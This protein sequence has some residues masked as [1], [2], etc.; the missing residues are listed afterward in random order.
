MPKTPNKKTVDSAIEKLNEVRREWMRRPGVTAVDVG[1]KI[2]D[3][4]M[5]DDVALRVHVARKKPVADLS[6]SEVFNTTGKSLTKQGGFPVDVIEG[7]YA[8][9]DVSTDRVALEDLMGEVGVGIERTTAFN[10]LV[11]G[12]SCG[13]PRVTAGTLGAIVFDRAS[14]RPMILSNWHVLAGGSAAAV[15]EDIL[16]PGRVDGGTEA[17]ATLTRMRL[18]SSM[19]AAVATLN[20]ARAHSRDIMNIGTVT[21]TD[22]ATLGMEVEKSGRTT[23][24]TKGIVDGVSMSVSIDYGDPGVVAFTNQIRIVPRPPWPAVD[25]EI[26][27]GGDSGSI[28]LNERTNRAVGL[29]FGG[30]RNPS[31]ASAENALANP[32]KPVASAL[33]F[34]FLPIFC[35]SRPIPTRPVFNICQRYPEICDLLIR[36]RI[37]IFNPPRPRPDPRPFD[38][39]RFLRQ[40][41]EMMEAEEHGGGGGGGCSCGGHSGEYDYGQ[42]Y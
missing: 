19:D 26:S 4:V 14:C 11:G 15:G 7:D 23:G 38:D 40:L 39:L 21:G 5:T 41:L 35:P 13:N 27:L 37:P 8:P 32:I 6:S 36:R 29:H 22:D 10:P 12:I 34:S 31:P 1:F 24:L 25:V 2:K 18:D 42:D 16:Q 30:E 20:N 3:K 9:A 28:W 17:V 33:N